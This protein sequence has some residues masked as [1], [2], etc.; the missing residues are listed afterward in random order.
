MKHFFYLLLLTSFF[1]CLTLNAQNKT[2]IDSTYA[3]YDYEKR[4]HPTI[5]PAIGYSLQTNWALALN[6]NLGFYNGGI[7]DT[8]DNISTINASITFTLND[9]IIF[10]IQAN[11][12]SKNKK[13]NWVTDLRYLQYPSLTYGLG[14]RSSIENE[15]T[16]TYNYIKIH[17]SILKK[18]VPN[19]YAGLGFYFDRYWD[20][21]ELDKPTT[22]STSFERYGF[23]SSEKAVGI[24]IKLLYDSRLNQINPTNGMFL[25]VIYRPSFSFLG[26]DNDWQSILIEARKYFHFPKNSKNILA[27]WNYNSLTMSGKPPYLF[28]PA[29]AWDDFYNT[30]RGY[31]QGRYRGREMMY[32]ESE[33]RFNISKNHLLGGVVFANAQSFS[34]DIKSQFSVIAPGYGAGLRIRIN[35]HTS[36][37]V[38]ID[39][40]FGKDGSNGLFVN[41]G[42]VF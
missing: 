21:E 15:S 26:S 7:S 29:T 4:L 30:G 35:K 36:T 32:F 41:L 40:A 12:W 19:L 9:Q 25:N 39:Y 2:A 42:E 23:S 28:L 17:Q 22:G 14:G 8:I 18:I 10:P 20:I 13:Y 38:C 11:I 31:I 24:P 37:N 34:K 5:L 6:Y 16:L 3:K 27:F 33:Y 1:Y